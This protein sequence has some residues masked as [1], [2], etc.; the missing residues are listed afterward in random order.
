MSQTISPQPESDWLLTRGVLARR[1][2]ALLADLM[3]LG[4][5][6]WS[7]AIFITL[8]GILTFG[9]GFLAFHILYWLPLFYYT[10]LVGNGGATPGQML[11]GLRVRQEG[12]LAPPTLSQGLVWSLLLW[13]SLALAC[14]PFLLAFT[15]SRHRAA[16][17]LLSG[18]VVVRTPKISY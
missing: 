11:F 17:D 12:N 3:V 5:L 9:I 15:N 16:H 1:F 7:L 10:L 8:L 14:V 18:L 13:L 4:M 2:F 6:C